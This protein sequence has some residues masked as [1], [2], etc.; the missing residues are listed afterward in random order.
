MSTETQE[1]PLAKL[2]VEIRSI[3]LANGWDG[4]TY[5]EWANPYKVPALLALVHTE[6]SEA[7]EAF[8]ADDREHF[9]EEM[10]DVVIR[11]LDCVGGLTGNFDAFLRAKLE[12]NRQRGYH[13]GTGKRI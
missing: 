1:T 6:V 10:A 9:L 3:N 5:E 2:A 13:H 8:H 4:L 12:K 7:M 11:V